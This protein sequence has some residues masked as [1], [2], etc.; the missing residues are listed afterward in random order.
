[1]F[2]LENKI[3]KSNKQ[4]KFYPIT[5]PQKKTSVYFRFRLNTRFFN[6]TY[7][8]GSLIYL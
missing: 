7:Y 4:S 2:C 6:R 3:T 1:M 5:A 8:Y